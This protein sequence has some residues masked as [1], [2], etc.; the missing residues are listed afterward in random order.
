MSTL[1]NTLRAIKV[2]VSAKTIK[3]TSFVGIKG[4]ENSKGEIS[5]QT[6]LVGFNLTNLL[7]KDLETL[8]AFDIQP[9]IQKYGKEVA[10]KAYSELL[11][12]LAKRTATEEEK[13]Q[14][15]KNADAT[16]KRSDAQIDA[17]ITIAKGIKQ[18][19]LRKDIKVYG[20]VVRKEVLIEG[21]YP[22]VNSAPKTLAKK[23][24]QK[25]ANLKQLKLRTLTFKDSKQVN[26]QGVSC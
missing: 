9:I 15:R 20:M 2:L 21:N 10:T 19:V 3:G 22:S 12:S 7:K 8:K 6:L 17:Y 13:E 24:I 25:Q 4:Y 5:N 18:G 14:L 26:L 11:T 23:D 16:I 1:K